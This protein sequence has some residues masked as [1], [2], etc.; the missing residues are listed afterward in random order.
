MLDTVSSLTRYN[1]YIAGAFVEPSGGEWFDSDNPFTAKPWAKVA[2]GNSKDVDRAVDA[3]YEAVYN[4]PWA[5][6]TA[7][8]RGAL[9][10]RMGDLITRD[11]DR[12]AHIESQDNGKL[13]AETGNQLRYSAN[14]Y[15]YYG[16]LADKIEGSVIP[17]D[18]KGYFNFT[19]Y[20]PLGVVALITPWNSPLLLTA[21]K[22]APALAAGNSVV[23]KPSEFTSVS[24]LELV[25]L[26]E[27]AG[28][29]PGL[30]NVVTGFGAEVGS[31]LVEHPKV[32][33]IAFTGSDATG[34]R[35]YAAAAMGMKHVT[36]EL[37]GKSP[38]IV[39]D[40]ADLDD[41]VKGATSG[42][43]A[44]TGQTC[45]A[46]S[47]LLLQ[48]SIHDAFLERLAEVARTARMGNPID[49]N[50]QI[51]PVTT[52]PQ[53]EKILHYIDVAKSEGARLV[54][55]GN[56]AKR[57]ECGNGWFVEPTIFADVT[58]DMTIAREEVFGPVLSVLRFKDEAEAL[59]IGNDTIY[60]LAS[61]VWT[62]DM[63]RA[64]RMARGL[65]AGTVWVNTYRAISYMSPFGGYGQSSLRMRKAF[66]ASASATTQPW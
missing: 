58:N 55:G 60:G 22:L 46:G 66:V 37:G 61:G 51:G 26:F 12:L 8:D 34:K 32:A 6:W 14:W 41:A 45:L 10:R 29:P 59:R 42:I 20:E 35:I 15:Y 62:K 23:I 19:E 33:K 1:H 53:F 44:A 18:K 64:I 3:A 30:I 31:A 24:V 57:P 21:W 38:N 11:A 47:R 36:M 2:R 63:G 49:P 25:K 5:S 52:P 56:A 48:D 40:D 28:A 17:L 9:L 7:S 39:F 54:A 4:G 27:E 16:G 65:R 50:T 43:F 13:I